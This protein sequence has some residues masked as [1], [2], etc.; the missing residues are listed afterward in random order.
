MLWIEFAGDGGD[1]AIGLDFADGAAIGKVE[2]TAGVD[3]KT[4]GPVQPSFCAFAI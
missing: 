3:G 4:F 1:S 2:V